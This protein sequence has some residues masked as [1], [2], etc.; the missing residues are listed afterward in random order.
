M[1]NSGAIFFQD[2]AQKGPYSAGVFADDTGA[3]PRTDWTAGDYDAPA[4]RF[5]L[6]TVQVWP[7]TIAARTGIPYEIVA[8]LAQVVSCLSL[9]CQYPVRPVSLLLQAMSSVPSALK[10]PTPA[11]VQADVSTALRIDHE[12]R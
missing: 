12:L 6:R 2:N 8:M 3:Q 7:L 4:V 10:S 5:C 9:I 1:F 11:S